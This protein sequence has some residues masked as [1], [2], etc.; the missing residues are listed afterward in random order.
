MNA[1][2]QLVQLLQKA[3]NELKSRGE[4]QYIG[5]FETRGEL[6]DFIL[7]CVS[8]IEA[9]DDHNLQRLGWGV[10][11]PTCDWD[12]AGG[13]QQLGNEVFDLIGRMLGPIDTS[14]DA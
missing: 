2:K 11:A 6:G 7:Q 1:R 3:G 8:E 5:D 12:D 4:L 13:S 9:E 10:F 14:T